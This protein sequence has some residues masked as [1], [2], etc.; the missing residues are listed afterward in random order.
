MI[1]LSERAIMIKR[2]LFI[3][4]CCGALAWPQAT[5]LSGIAHVAFRVADVK[6]SRDFYQKLGFEQAFE[7]TKEGRTTEAFIKINDR[8][9]L[10]LYPREGSEPLGLMH[11][12]YE[13]NELEALDAEY[14]KRDVKPTPVRKA[15]AGN[16]LFTMKDPEGQTV[17]YT[18]YLPGSRHFEDHGKHLGP[19]RVSEHLVGASVSVKDLAAGRAYYTG[20][21]AFEATGEG[22][23]ARLRLPGGSGEVVKLEAAGKDTRPTLFFEVP[24]AHVSIKDLKARGFEVDAGNPAAVSVTDPDGAVM[25]FQNSER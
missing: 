23:E 14:V 16:L 21:L 11:V 13:S 19:Q 3:G 25:V 1:V 18:Q 10:E 6:V 5:K 4:I 12:C 8:Q 15:G 20:K 24:D 22:E 9:F 17:E 2:T 7:F